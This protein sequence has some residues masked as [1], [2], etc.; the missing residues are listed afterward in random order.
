MSNMKIWEALKT[1]DPKFTKKVEFGRK[2]T[3]INSQYQLQRMT[4]QFGPI[5]EGWGYIVNHSIER[6][7]DWHVLAVA[8]VEIWWGERDAVGQ[9]KSYGPIRGTAPVLEPARDKGR[10]LF[11]ADGT[12]V[13]LHL[14]DDAGKKAMTDALTKG[15]SHLGLSADV[16][17]GLFDDNKYV[18][19]VREQFASGNVEGRMPPNET[20]SM[21]IDAVDPADRDLVK[22]GE[23]RSAYRVAADAKPPGRAAA[24]FWASSVL[25]LFK[26]PRY[27]LLDYKEWKV[28][29]CTNKSTKTNE[30]KLAE[31]REKHS[32][33]ADKI[34]EA[35]SNIAAVAA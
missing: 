10:L 25:M 27:A 21:P 9:R 4:E 29:P 16:F 28:T 20:A 34:D 1:T 35:V 13:K 2:F 23:T 3:S 7:N 33:L 12:T 32:D 18:Q 22:D 26:Q 6:L 8:D 17:L 31:L 24:E 30:Q 5:G 19:N 14:D 15:L 11:E